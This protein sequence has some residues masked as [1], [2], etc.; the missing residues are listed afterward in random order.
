MQRA[1]GRAVAARCRHALFVEEIGVNGLDLV[2]LSRAHADAVVD[3]EAGERGAVDEHDR[4]PQEALSIFAGIL[5]E[6]SRGDEKALRYAL[7]GKRPDERLN[8]R[9]SDRPLRIP[10]LSLVAD[11]SKSESVLTDDAVY[12]LVT[13]LFGDVGTGVQALAVTHR[14]EQLSDQVLEEIRSFPM[15]IEMRSSASA[16]RISP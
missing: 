6:A 8:L 1:E 2:D 9:P 3:H 4:L 5:G 12:P 15:M 16:S 11:G 13:T 7:S 10:P 14:H